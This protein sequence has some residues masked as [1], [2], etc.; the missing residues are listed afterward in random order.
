MIKKLYFHSL[1]MTDYCNVI[2]TAGL[3]TILYEEIESDALYS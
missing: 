1:T 2:L 3:M